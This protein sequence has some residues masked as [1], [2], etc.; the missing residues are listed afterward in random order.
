MHVTRAG[1]R[2]AAVVWME[3]VADDQYGATSSS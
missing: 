1:A 3:H 2:P